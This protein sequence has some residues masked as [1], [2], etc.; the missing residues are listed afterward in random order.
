M[1]D[2]PGSLPERVWLTTRT[3]GVDGEVIARRALVG[4]EELLE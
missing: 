3:T 1:Y 4:V 2:V